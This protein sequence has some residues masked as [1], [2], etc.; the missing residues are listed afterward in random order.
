MA[1]ITPNR[2]DGKISSYRFRSCVGRD[3][4]GKQIFRS[5][6]WYVPEGVTPSKAERLANKAVE[7]WE[8]EVRLEYQKDLQDSQ[9]VKDREIDKIR[10]EFRAFVLDEWFVI[11]INNG[12]HKPNTIDFYKN[13]AVAIVEY[14][15]NR[16]LQKITATEIQKYLIYLRSERGLSPQT[17]HHY[18][19]TLNMMFRFAVKQEIIRANPMDKVERPTIPRRKVDA[20]SQEEAKAFLE[21]IEKCPLDFRC[22]LQLF[23]TTG[24]RRGECG[25]LK[26]KDIDEKNGV[27]RIE[28]SV[29]YTP[30]SGIVVSTPK[31]A[32]SVRII[33]L[34]NSSLLLLK[35]LREQIEKQYPTTIIKEAFVFPSEKDLFF[36]KDPHAIT[37]RVK[38]FMKR[39]GLPD[40]S[41]HDLRHSCATLLLAQGADVKSVQQ[42]LG[43]S[44]ASVT[45]NFY[46]RSDLRQMQDATN[47]LAMAFGL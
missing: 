14:F 29:S 38:R 33:P 22:M 41:P 10:T 2:K 15:G 21:A 42:I 4:E 26:W 39:N 31:T 7:L 34:T 25:G 3:E 44:D 19:R 13:I 30:Q 5:M 17:V 16:V 18:H 11:C 23:L 32:T 43:H 47:K 12:E 28:R 20:F 9:R 27:L 45:L 6:T 8:Q 37:R 24:M 36:P 40:L 1:T 35:R 46:V